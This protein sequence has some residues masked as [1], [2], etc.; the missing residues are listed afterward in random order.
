LRDG[1]TAD[2]DVTAT[3]IHNV[4]RSF[5]P[6]LHIVPVLPKTKNGKLMRRAMRARYLGAPAGDLSALDPATPLESIPNGE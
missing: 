1:V 2:D 6:T 3:A 5:A 4:G